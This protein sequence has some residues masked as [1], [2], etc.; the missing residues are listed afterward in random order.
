MHS[1]MCFNGATSGAFPVSSCVKQGCVLVPTLFGIFFS[2]LLQYAF[3]DCS[4][5]VYIHT[6]ADGKPFN[7]ASLR[8]KTKVRE[9]LIREMLFADDASLV[10]HTEHGLQ[11]LVSS[12][13]AACKEFGLSISLKKTNV[14]DQGTDHSPTIAIDGHVTWRLLETSPTLGPLSQA[15]TH[16]KQKWAA[17]SPRPQQCMLKLHH[18]IWNNS[19][20]TEKTKMRVYEACVLSTLYSSEAWTPHARH[21]KRLHS[22]HL[23]CLRRVLHVRWQDKI[24][25]TEILQRAGMKSMVAILRERRLR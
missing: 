14:M 12:F 2:M 9:V 5:G 11:Q 17:E 1:T 8:A 24:P 25:D 6:T 4:E 7:I 20:L 18:R 15:R 3:K 16:W 19:S 13:S 22:F 23:R 10:L 21:E